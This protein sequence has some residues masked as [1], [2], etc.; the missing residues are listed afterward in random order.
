MSIGYVITDCARGIIQGPGSG[1]LPL[2]SP[3]FASA[4]HEQFAIFLTKYSKVYED[5]PVGR[6]VDYA[7]IICNLAKRKEGKRKDGEKNIFLIHARGRERE[8]EK[9]NISLSPIYCEIITQRFNVPAT[10]FFD[11]L[12]TVFASRIVPLLSI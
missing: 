4:C 12:T 8:R 2:R 10:N 11:N 6:V 1:D 9:F 7:A 5:A 3:P